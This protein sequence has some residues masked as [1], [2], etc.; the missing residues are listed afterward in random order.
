MINAELQGRRLVLTV[1]T[2]D[3]EPAIEPFRIDPLSA[4]AGRELS[5]NY[6][7]A[8]EG[9]VD[10]I[11]I[12]ADMLLAVGKANYER[13]D[14]ELT[15]HE[16]ELLVRVAYFWQTVAGMDAV[17]ALLELDEHGEQGGESGKG[18]ALAAF[19]LRVV[20]LL[21]RIRHLLESDRQT[22]MVGTPGTSSPDGGD[23]SVS[24]L[25]SEPKPAPPAAPP[26]SSS[27]ET[28]D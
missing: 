1:E 28:H 22:S 12:E 18:K 16:G 7:F 24:R 13:A 25:D 15:Q 9:L 21:S 3:D 2:A 17:R 4:K 5:K 26:E 27:H 11:D 6:L 10:G 23:D 19:R 8:S 20:P 14:D